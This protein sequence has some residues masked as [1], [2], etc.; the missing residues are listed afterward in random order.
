MALIKCGECGKS[1]SDKAAACPNCGA[2]I[3]K[4]AV[5][6]KDLKDLVKDVKLY[7][8]RGA[9]YSGY[10]LGHGCATVAPYL[11]LVPF[12]AMTICG[13]G[14]K[15]YG[16][17]TYPSWIA[18]LAFVIPIAATWWMRKW[19]WGVGVICIIL[20]FVTPY[21]KMAIP[22]QDLPATRPEGFDRNDC[23]YVRAENIQKQAW[24]VEF[25]KGKYKPV[26]A[27]SNTNSN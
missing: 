3:A 7:G 9:Y 24:A 18:F 21:W 4:P 1:V 22:P 14:V 25:C 2:P 27:V 13:L 26:K 8:P 12:L 10:E 19:L 11:A 5:S 20:F 23:S 6:D 17:Y 15:F 16:Q